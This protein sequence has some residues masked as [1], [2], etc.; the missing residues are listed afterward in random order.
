M[1]E[2]GYHFRITDIQSALA[3]SQLGKI[4][5]FLAKRRTLVARYDAAF[6]SF[7]H[8][9]PAQSTGRHESGHHLYVVRIDF[10]AIGSSRAEVMHKLRARNIGTQ[11]HYIPVPA[12]PF[13]RRLGFRPEDYPH[14]Q[15]Y[16]EEALTIP[17]FYDLTDA[18]Q[19]G[20]ISALRELAG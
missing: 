13:Y 12:Q 6:A 5:K 8:C 10:G 18:E 9:R 17:L 7:R 19:E 11:V 3:L 20:V 4:E 16:Y 2:L 1:Q 15:R 14:A